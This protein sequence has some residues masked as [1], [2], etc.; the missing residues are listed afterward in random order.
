GLR[1][2]P[3]YRP[4]NGTVSSFGSQSDCVFFSFTA[5]ATASCVAGLTWAKQKISTRRSSPKIDNSFCVLCRC[6][7]VGDFVVQFQPLERCGLG[8]IEPEFS[9]LLAEEIALF[10]IVVESV[11]F[12]FLAPACDFFR[13]F[14]FAIA[15]EPFNHFL[16]ARSVFNLGFEIVT[17]HALETEQRVIERAIKVIFTDV[18]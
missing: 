7:P 11:H 2:G 4:N 5:L 15:V 12:H 9:G 3:P 17:L 16:I 6:L 13:P 18:P 14:L 1:T 8:W 10:R